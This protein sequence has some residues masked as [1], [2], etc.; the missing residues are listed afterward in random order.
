MWIYSQ[1]LGQIWDPKGELFTVAYSGC[2]EG[3]NSPR[4]QGQKNV[5]PI[6]RGLYI[7]GASYH[8]ERVGPRALPLVPINHNALGRTDFLIHGDNP[9][10]DAS[11]GCVIC[12]PKERKI[13]DE[14]EDKMFLVIE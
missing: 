3:R 5:G 1:A 7:I 10:H 9:S 6:P 8:S 11:R 14:H 4:H 2:G 13:I 12:G